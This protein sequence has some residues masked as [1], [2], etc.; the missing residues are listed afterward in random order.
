LAGLVLEGGI[1][2]GTTGGGGTSGAGTVFEA[3]PAGGEKVLYS[4]CPQANCPDGAL[5]YAG[6]VFDAKRDLFYG[7]TV[8][9]GIVECGTGYGCGVVFEVNRLGRE[10]PLWSF[11]TLANCA[12]GQYPYAGLVLDAKGNL[13]G[14]TEAGGTNGFGAVFVLV[15]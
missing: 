11:C 14:T 15:P 9:G 2:Y 7:T 1:L 13:Y 4:F 12:D 10:T 5:P 8:E 6:L 3:T